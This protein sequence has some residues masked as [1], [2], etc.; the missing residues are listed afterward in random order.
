[1]TL[2]RLGSCYDEVY[3]DGKSTGCVW[4]TYGLLVGDMFVGIA[5]G[6]GIAAGFAQLAYVARFSRPERYIFYIELFRLLKR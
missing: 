6:I 3:L 5:N 2:T 4:A 1:M